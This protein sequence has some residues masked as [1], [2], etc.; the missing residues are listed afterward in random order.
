MPEY[1]KIVHRPA[2]HAAIGEIG[3][4]IAGAACA[5]ERHPF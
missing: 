4:H 3:R 2:D 5:A 1:C